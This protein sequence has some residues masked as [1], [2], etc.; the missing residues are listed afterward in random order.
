MKNVIEDDDIDLVV[1]GALRYAMGRSSYM[2]G[3]MQDFIQRHWE[4]PSIIGKQNIIL[5]DLEQFIHDSVT[6]FNVKSDDDIHL[7]WVR[8]FEK[9]KERYTARN[10]HEYKSQLVTF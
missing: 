9:L 7:T 8:L 5:R 1:I 6:L 10:G 2:V 3:V 4:H